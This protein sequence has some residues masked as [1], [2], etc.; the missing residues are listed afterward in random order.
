[1]GAPRKEEKKRIQFVV[2]VEQWKIDLLGKELIR[3]ICDKAIE[4]SI[5]NR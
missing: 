4:E 3:E 5:K 2:P 1:M